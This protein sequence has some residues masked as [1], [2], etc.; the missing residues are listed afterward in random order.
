MKKSVY[1]LLSGFLVWLIPFAVS[2]GVFSYKQAGSPLFETV[3]AVTITLIG[4]VFTV[5]YLR[6]IRWGFL[7][8]GFV[9]GMVFML[10]SIGLDMLLF[11]WGPMTMTFAGYVFNNPLVLH[12]HELPMRMALLDYVLDVGITYAV[13]PVISVGMGYILEKK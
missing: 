11:I 2:I 6:K 12:V 5:S 9:I 1:L 8:E 3:M 10:M 7:K 13:Y 4:T